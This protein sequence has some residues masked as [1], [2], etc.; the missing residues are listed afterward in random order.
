MGLWKRIRDSWRQA[1]ERDEEIEKQAIVDRHM[2]DLE[3]QQQQQT[4]SPRLPPRCDR[5]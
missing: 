2:R 3:R 1:K 4:H 5:G